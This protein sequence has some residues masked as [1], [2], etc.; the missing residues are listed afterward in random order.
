MMRDH[1]Q[2]KK[3]HH[4]YVGWNCR[5]D[6]IQ[7]A[8]LNVKLKY[9]ENWTEARIKNACLYNELLSG[10]EGITVPET[11]QYCRHVYHVYP[12]LVEKRDMLISFLSKNNVH[13]G[14][15]YPVP[16]HLTEA[17]KALGYGKG[18]LPVSE[19]IAERLLSLPMYPELQ[20]TEIKHIVSLIKKFM[21]N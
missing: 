6:G 3:Y 14:I 13:C 11:Q 19:D 4:A 1:G 10:I 12:I 7:G 18:S 20:D 9:I 8:V 16:L 15:H 5:M 2:N 17:Y 21:N